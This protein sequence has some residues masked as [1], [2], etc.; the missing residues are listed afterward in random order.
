MEREDIIEPHLSPILTKKPARQV[1]EDILD[2]ADLSNSIYQPALI[3][4]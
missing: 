3:S 1:R 2:S 4:Q